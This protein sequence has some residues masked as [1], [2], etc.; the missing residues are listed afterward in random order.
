MPL[1][2]FI[3]LK[4]KYTVSESSNVAPM[5]ITLPFTSNPLGHLIFLS[6]SS[7]IGIGP[8]REYHFKN[9]THV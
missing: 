7:Y 6:G 9:A 5:L 1:A 8:G 2:A 3:S 4:N